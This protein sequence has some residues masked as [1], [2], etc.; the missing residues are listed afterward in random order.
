MCDYKFGEIMKK[1]KIT[2]YVVSHNHEKYLSDALESVL[3]QTIDGWEFLI[4]DDGSEDKSREIIDLYK[5]D[6]RVQIFHTDG[7][8]LPSVCNLA[9]E[10]ARGEYIVRLDGDDI[11]D[12]NILLVLSNYLDSN[13]ETALVFP[14]YFLID[15][16][17]EIFAHER[18]NKIFD[19]NHVVD[20][21]PNGACT[22]IRINML[23][24]AGGYREDLGA[25]D[26]FDM[27]TKISEK[28]KTGNVNL[29]LFYYRRHS[30]N[31]TNRV[32][33][34]H[35]A[36]RQIKHDAIHAD[37]EKNKPFIVV[38]PCRKNYDFC[39]DVWKQG[40]GSQ[41][42]LEV[43]IEESLASKIIDHVVVA[44]DNQEAADV[45]K[46]YSDKRLSFYL[47]QS[48][49][50]IRSQK[51]TPVIKA[52]VEELDP[53]FLGI[54]A[55]RYI[56]SPFV[57]KETIEE[58]VYTLIL[59]S[60]DSTVGVEAITRPVYKRTAFGLEDLNPARQFKTDFDQVFLEANTVFATRNLNLK[61]GSLTGSK[62]ANFLVSSDECYFI[63]TH[64][65]LKIAQIMA[66]DK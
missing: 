23:K 12:E 40:V 45:V 28:H 10:K 41:T 52:I 53:E 18:R 49:E 50:T 32:Q 14:D 39:E 57:N 38:I 22:M 54:T 2:V 21:P 3:R 48:K 8:G 58:A 9:L 36:K 46:S 61:F 20:I 51:I 25:Q 47:R 42:L 43:A 35:N 16:F 66:G 56:Q 15:E 63:D 64:K 6:D 1:P 7:I 65:K 24:E 29:P 55:L 26:G 4:I 13:P 30:D 37:L 44:C 27:W 5:G 19:T 17:N 62:R 34:I 11:F 33:F 60:V 59:N 31:L